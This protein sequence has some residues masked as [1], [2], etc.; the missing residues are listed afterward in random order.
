MTKQI[1]KQIKVIA[2]ILE[3][4]NIEL[5][6]YGLAPNPNGFCFE[7]P[8]IDD[9]QNNYDDT[10]ELLSDAAKELTA[11]LASLTKQEEK[12]LINNYL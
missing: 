6:S 9:V 3:Q 5:I 4:F 2:E 12:Y 8:Y 7:T 10:Q 1:T 11:L